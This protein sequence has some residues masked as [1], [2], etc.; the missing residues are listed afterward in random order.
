MKTIRCLFVSFFLIIN[1]GSNIM[2]QSI[3]LSLNHNYLPDSEVL[4]QSYFYSTKENYLNLTLYKIKDVMNFYQKFNSKQKTFKNPDEINDFSD[5]FEEVVS[6]KER[7]Y[8]DNYGNTSNQKKLG[9]FS[10]IG[11]YFLVAQ[12]GKAFAYRIFTVSDIGWIAKNSQNKTLIYLADRKTSEPV[13]ADIRILS[14][15]GK[16][17]SKKTD[18]DGL[19]LISEISLINSD[20]I[21]IIVKTEKGEIVIESDFRVYSN[22]YEKYKV[23]TYTNQPVYRPGLKVSFKSVIRKTDNFELVPYANEN[24][25]VIVLNPKNEKVYQKI[26]KTNEFGSLS[27]DLLLEENTK[28]GEYRINLGINGI[29]YTSSFQVEEY[30]KPEYKVEITTDK[31]QYTNLDKIKAKIKADYYF[32]SPVTN[33]KVQYQ[34]FRTRFFR[35]WWYYD[36]YNWIYRAYFWDDY[37][38]NSEEMVYNSEGEIDKDGV[39]EFEYTIDKN[40]AENYEYRIVAKVIDQSRREIEGSKKIIVAKTDFQLTTNPE[41]YLYKPSE[42]IAVKI[43]AADF[44]DNP[45]KTNFNVYLRKRINEFNNEFIEEIETFSGETN[46]EG[47][48]YV[49]FNCEEA[50]IYSYSVKAKDSKKN[51]VSANGNFWV[52][53]KNKYVW[54]FGGGVQ[55]ITDKDVYASNEQMEIMI[56]SPVKDAKALLTFESSEFLDIKVLDIDNYNTFYKIKFKENGPAL[57]TISFMFFFGNSYY[58]GIKKIA[59]I[60][61]TKFLSLEIKPSK[62]K[63]KPNEK[64]SY[65]VKV[66]D[67]NGKVVPKTELSIGTTDESIYAIK[68]EINGDIKD[69]FYSGSSSNIT[70]RVCEIDNYYYYGNEEQEKEKDAKE[71]GDLLLNGNSEINGILL[72][73]QTE[74]PLANCKVILRK[75]DEQVQTKT[76]KKGYFEFEKVEEGKYSIIFIYENS[77]YP[78]ASKV[79]KNIKLK[80]KETLDIGKIFYNRGEKRIIRHYRNSIKSYSPAPAN[81]ISIVD[82]RDYAMEMVPTT[83]TEVQGSGSFVKAEVRTD[84]RDAILW[85]PS[86]ITDENGEAKIDIKYPENLTTWRATI[87]ANTLDSKFGQNT[88]KTITRKDLIIRMETPRVLHE[89]D[90]VTI[91][92]IIH[93]YLTE[94]KM[95]KVEFNIK[96]AQLISS[97]VNNR[98]EEGTVQYEMKNGAYFVEIPK[99]KELRIDW[100]IKVTEP[101]KEV[102]FKATAETNEESDGI[103]KK[104]PLKPYGVEMVESDALS[105]Q[106]KSDEAKT[107]IKIPKNI[108]MRNATL[109]LKFAPSLAGTIFGALDE[110]VAYPYG[111]VEQTMSRFLPAIVVANT[112]NKIDVKVKSKTMTELPKV[113]N[114]GLRKLYDYQHSDGGWGWWQNDQTNPYM[115]AYVMYGLSLSKSSDIAIENEIYEK[116]MQSLKNQIFNTE[117]RDE[118]YLAY[119]LY[120]LSMIDKNYLLKEKTKVDKMLQK[121]SDNENPYIMALLTMVSNNLDL[122]NS[123]ENMKNLKQA[124]TLEGLS[125]YWGSNDWNY[126]WH[127]DKVQITALSVRALLTDNTNMDLIEKAIRWLMIKRTG[128]YWSSTLQTSLVVLALNDYLLKTNELDPDFSIKINANGKEIF[129]KSFTK[130]DVYENEIKLEL[131]DSILNSGDNTIEIKKEGEGKFYY[132]SSLKYY[133]KDKLKQPISEFFEIEREYF[134]VKNVQED[135]NY[136]NVLNKL[137]GS[138]NSGDEILV[139]VTIKTEQDREYFMLEEPIPAGCEVIKNG[140]DKI[141]SQQGNRPNWDRP[142]YNRYYGDREIHDDR[143]S[144]FVT[145][146]GKGKMELYYLLKAQIPGKYVILPSVGSLM[147][148]P[149]VRGSDFIEELKIK[150]D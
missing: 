74:E 79:I 41:K 60:P 28:L 52:S 3:N 136:V 134:K 123:K 99:E 21:L 56:I 44:N 127:Q 20:P 117:V 101:G 119:M 42:R 78:M 59:V 38:H 58:S 82:D 29:S 16:V 70:T 97:I 35:P 95:T 27:D 106:K 122:E 11:T 110:L 89:N 55:I 85:L 8:S 7:L 24:V 102:I 76:N 53:D 118:N 147:Y 116:G 88:N 9:K 111:C 148:Y 43:K 30:K 4:L 77:D 6:Y 121:M 125:A 67:S 39:L 145:Y 13:M 142:V 34:I 132:T 45:V 87:R 86:V 108:E 105:L 150:E 137:K 49:Y 54:D 114:A 98:K 15:S 96:N 140:E 126:R 2:S 65:L 26:L 22:E 84:F 33:A 31:N 5:C 90:E 63:Y 139:K 130:K 48:G 19:C 62:D 135:D 120:V 50:G 66:K 46:N 51:I 104:V 107:N 61:K 129:K 73:D 146:L 1:A 47:I 36:D 14:E 115:T 113:I 12:S 10:K 71:Y 68:E 18:K 131:N 138:V 109:T 112:L 103:E 32:G 124:A 149:E 69:Y 37:Y 92:T 91:S 143:I 23:Y 100:K 80:S 17:I 141:L 83:K 94:N 64:G 25:S 128:A 40:E 144:F 75:D 57:S 81:S 133:S 72:D 93:N